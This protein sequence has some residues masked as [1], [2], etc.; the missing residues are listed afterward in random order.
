MISRFCCC[1]RY[2]F[3]V[4]NVKDKILRG[5]FAVEPIFFMQSRTK[6]IDGT[7]LFRRAAIDRFFFERQ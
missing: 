7:I 1:F 3:G 6:I 5:D 4:N 2:E